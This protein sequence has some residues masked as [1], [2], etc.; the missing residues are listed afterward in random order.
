MPEPPQIERSPGKDAGIVVLFF[1]LLGIIWYVQGGPE[2]TNEKPFLEAE[3]TSKATFEFTEKDVEIS[4]NK[5]DEKYDLNKCSGYLAQTQTFEPELPILCPLPKNEN[6]SFLLS[7]RCLSYIET[8]PR[9]TTPTSVPTSLGEKC[10][11]EIAEKLNYETCV[12]EHKWDRD[13]YLYR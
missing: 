2:K 5:N 9:C 3:P 11:K 7:E 10:A 12:K 6:W 1:I 8:I 4:K 13:F